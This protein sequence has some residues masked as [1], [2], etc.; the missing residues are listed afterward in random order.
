[1]IL[2]YNKAREHGSQLQQK[3]RTWFS[4]TTK[5]ENLVLNYNKTREHGSQLQQNQRTWF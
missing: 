3:H 1:M 2:N 5:P 4:I